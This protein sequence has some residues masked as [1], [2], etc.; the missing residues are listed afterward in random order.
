MKIGLCI[1]SILFL[2]WTTYVRNKT[3]C[4]AHGWKNN[5]GH[6]IGTLTIAITEGGAW[7]LIFKAFLGF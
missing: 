2:L 7:Y 5:L 1:P 3:T 4:E 6:Y